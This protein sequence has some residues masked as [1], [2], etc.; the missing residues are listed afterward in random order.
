MHGGIGKT[1]YAT[2]ISLKE[3]CVIFEIM[4]KFQYVSQVDDLPLVHKFMGGLSHSQYNSIGEFCIDKH[5][6]VNI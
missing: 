1:S 6:S 3:Q 5:H 4:I 2:I